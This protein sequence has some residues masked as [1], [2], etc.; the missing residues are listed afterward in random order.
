VSGHTVGEW[1]A[2]PNGSGD[3]LVSGDHQHTVAVVGA[4]NPN[5]AADAALIAAAPMMAEALAGIMEFMESALSGSIH[6]DNWRFYDA[7][8]CAALRAAGMIE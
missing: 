6:D 1:E 2:R 8:I 3:I 7:K 4:W 5:A